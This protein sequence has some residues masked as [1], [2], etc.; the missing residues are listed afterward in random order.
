MWR[1]YLTVGFRALTKNRTYAFINIFGLALGLAACLI[2]LLYVRYETSYDSWLPGRRPHLPGPGDQPQRQ[3]KRAARPIQ[4]AH[5]VVAES[6]ARA[7]PEIEAATRAEGI[8][9][10]VLQG[11]EAAD[12]RPASPPKPISSRSCPSSSSAASAARALA[13]MNSMAVSRE[14]AIKLF[15]T[16]RC[17]RQ[18][19]RGDHL[20][21]AGRFASAA[22]SRTCRATATCFNM[23]R[24]ITEAREGNAAAGNASTATSI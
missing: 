20:R 22:C 11:G 6:L 12:F 9:M 21:R 13:D 3:R 4:A 17:R 10:T 18:D 7:F 8:S 14:Q 5:G 2:L 19:G 15:G 1:N 16:D 24:R 23:V